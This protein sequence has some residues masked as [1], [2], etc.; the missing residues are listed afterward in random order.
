MDKERDSKN[1]ENFVDALYV[2]SLVG[3][4]PDLDDVVEEGEE[5]REGERSNEQGY[6]AVLN[7]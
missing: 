1:S 3:V 4:Q 5:R 6:E 2:P 7:H